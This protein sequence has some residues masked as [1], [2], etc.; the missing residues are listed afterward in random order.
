MRLA[1]MP[2]RD[3]LEGEALA[4]RLVMRRASLRG[5]GGEGAAAAAAAGLGRPLY[6]PGNDTAQ[7]KREALYGYLEQVPPGG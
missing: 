3:F 6:P 4:G 2:M 1:L 7:W 5:G